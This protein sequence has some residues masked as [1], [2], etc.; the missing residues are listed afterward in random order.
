MSEKFGLRQQRNERIVPSLVLADIDAALSVPLLAGREVRLK[1]GWSNSTR[2]PRELCKNTVSTTL[3]DF[4]FCLISSYRVALISASPCF[5][6]GSNPGATVPETFTEDI[7]S[8]TPLKRS[9]VAPFL[10]LMAT[11]PYLRPQGSK[12]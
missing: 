2:T 10:T 6:T 7:L 3:Y 11:C 4:I 5:R 8:K 9:D 12:Q 1:L